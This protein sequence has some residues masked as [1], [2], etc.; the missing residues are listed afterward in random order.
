MKSGRFLLAL[1][2]GCVMAGCAIST[3]TIKG[4]Y[5][6]TGPEDAVVSEIE[7]DGI[8]SDTT[9]SCQAL[10]TSLNSTVRRI[11]R[12]MEKSANLPYVGKVLYPFYDATAIVSGSTLKFCEDA[13]NRLRANKQL[14]VT[15]ECVKR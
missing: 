9:E 1:A 11:S 10:L 15:Q 3:M 13:L 7:I 14:K 8:A 5:L 6:Q 2:C 4:H 12:C